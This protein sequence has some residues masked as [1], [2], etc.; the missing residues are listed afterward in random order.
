M[1]AGEGQHQADLRVALAEGGQLP[2]RR[3]RGQGRPGDH[4]VPGSVVVL[5]LATKSSYKDKK[6][7]AWV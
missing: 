4:Q 6:T 3:H 2:G 1:A 7:N 5:S